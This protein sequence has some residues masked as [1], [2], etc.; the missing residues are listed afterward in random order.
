MNNKSRTDSYIPAAIKALELSGIA[1]DGKIDSSY[2]GQISSFGAA[3]TIGSFKQAVAFFALDAKNGVSGISRSDLILAIDYIL[4]PENYAN[5]VEEKKTKIADIKNKILAE[6]NPQKLKALENRYLDAAVALKVAM[7]V[8][9][10]S[11]EKKE[12]EA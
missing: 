6:E 10:M 1:K 8:Y 7:G 2:R 9:D 12:K 3:V 5:G 4:N 11:P